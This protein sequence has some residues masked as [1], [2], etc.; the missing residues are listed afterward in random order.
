MRL[1]SAPV[2]S[3]IFVA[4]AAGGCAADLSDDLDESGAAIEAKKLSYTP[5]DVSDG[6]AGLD[7]WSPVGLTDGG[8]VYGQAFDCDDEFIVCTFP[9]VKRA[10][11]GAFTTLHPNFQI[12]DVDEKGNVG[13]CTIDD[14]DTFF[15]Q[16]AVVKNNGDLERLPKLPGEIT[17]CILRLADDRVAAVN[18]VNEAF[19]LTTY[20]FNKGTVTPFT[21]Q[22][23]IEDINDRGQIVG[24]ISTPGAN[25]G[26]RFDAATATTTVLEPIAG[27]PHTW[28]QAINEHGEVLGYSFTFDATERIGKWNRNGAFEV[29]FTEGTPE[30]PTISNQL[31]WNEDGLIVISFI[32]NEGNT[33][34]VPEPG[35]RLNLADLVGG[36][37]IPTT[38]VALTVNKRGDLLTF[39]LEDFRAFVFVRN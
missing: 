32:P 28:A 33:Y 21:L 36:A 9:L 4:L 12:S 15:G 1:S 14:P 24:V 6:P 7:G 26:Y 17:S 37:D 13:G 20:V 39:S 22:A 31:S 34:L 29:A 25:R 10:P 18:S 11:N 3:L 19:E 38:L 30:F 8:D 35:T 2:V 16:A 5:I 27:D 23:S